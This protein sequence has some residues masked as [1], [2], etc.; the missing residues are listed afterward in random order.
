MTCVPMQLGSSLLGVDFMA[1]LLQHTEVAA[2]IHW[3]SY[4]SSGRVLLVVVGCWWSWSLSSWWWKWSWSWWWAKQ[5]ADVCTSC[6]MPTSPK[7]GVPGS[8]SS[9]G[10]GGGGSSSSSSSS[11]EFAAGVESERERAIVRW[12]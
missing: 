9:G 1:E 6:N 8:S 5:V 2:W 10:G 11:D 12:I 7:G 4:C 3:A